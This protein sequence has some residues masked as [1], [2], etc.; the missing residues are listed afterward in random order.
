M[1]PMRI[2]RDSVA[3]LSDKEIDLILSMFMSLP[4]SNVRTVPVEMD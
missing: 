3:R 2:L 4:R 1:K